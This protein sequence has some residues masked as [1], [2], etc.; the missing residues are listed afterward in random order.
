MK[1]EVSENLA[2]RVEFWGDY[3]N[4]AHKFSN[5]T[6]V[7]GDGQSKATHA[8]LLASISDLLRRLLLEVF[9]PEE[10]LV[11]ILPDHS[12]EELELC[13]QAVMVGEE[14]KG[15]EGVRQDLGIVVRTTSVNN[16]TK[17]DRV[18]S[19]NKWPS[20]IK[21]NKQK[22]ISH[23]ATGTIDMELIHK[24]LKL[25]YKNDLENDKNIEGKQVKQFK[26]QH[27]PSTFM[28]EIGL[29]MHFSKIHEFWWQKHLNIVGNEYSCK[30]C[31]KTLKKAKEFR[32]HIFQEHKLVNT[33]VCPKC[34]KVFRKNRL[35]THMVVHI[36]EPNV[37]CDLCGLK[38]KSERLVNV[39]KRSQHMTN[40]EKL[41]LLEMFKCKTCDKRC[42]S[43]AKLA[44]HSQRHGDL[45][46]QCDIC[47]TRYRFV[48]S[49]RIHK[50]DKHSGYKPKQLTQ[51]QLEKKREQIRLNHVIERQKQKE[52][53]G[54]V[55]RIGEERIKFNQYMKNWN[56]KRRAKNKEN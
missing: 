12:M 19:L 24:T 55:L 8:L 36:E 51:E 40:E 22:V 13:F 47:D 42:L 48:D 53:N 14:G 28:N 52:K 11:I 30:I 43:K 31:S 41:Y 54:G 49:L 2:G 34:P 39:H 38:Y 20:E 33:V 16:Q 50:R 26:C 6:L 9:S 56:A 7:S 37:V 10:R 21:E 27:C 46:H 23:D 25:E 29:S 45:I 1:S 35:Q 18:G 44:I 5:V 32:K 4:A 3:L 15:E 17:P